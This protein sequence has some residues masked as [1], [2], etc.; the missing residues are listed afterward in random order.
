MNAATK[1][2]LEKRVRK[3]YQHTIYV[4]IPLALN[5]RGYYKINHGQPVDP[6][7]DEDLVPGQ[8]GQSDGSSA[9]GGG[10]LEGGLDGSGGNTDDWWKAGQYISEGE[11]AEEA[12]EAK[13]Y[14]QDAIVQAIN[15]LPKSATEDEA[16]IVKK[17]Q[18]QV[19]ALENE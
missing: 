3:E 4:D 11:R 16:S 6:S 8:F 12:A 13:R 2:V 19:Q 18:L 10:D 17:Y 14:I 5:K 7:L 15:R 1:T 9:G